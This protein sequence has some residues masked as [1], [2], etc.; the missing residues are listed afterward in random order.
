MESRSL[1]ALDGMLTTT[2]AGIAPEYP[3][4]IRSSKF[5]IKHPPTQPAG[6]GGDT[7]T[8]FQVSG[9]AP[10]FYDAAMYD[11]IMLAAVAINACLKDGCRP[12]GHGYDEVMPYFRA[13]SIDGISGPTSIKVGSNDPEGRLFS[14]RWGKIQP[15]VVKAG[16]IQS[17]KWR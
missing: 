3:G 7:I 6:G 9:R 5:W 2:P 4:M 8:P 16:R 13:T 12:V 10:R 17:T 14:V 11:A 1:D 15:V